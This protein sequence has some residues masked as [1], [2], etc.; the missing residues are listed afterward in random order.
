[1]DVNEDSSRTLVRSAGAMGVM[2]LM[3]RVLGYVRDLLLAAILGAAGSSDAFIIALRIPNLLRRL[4][5][6][7]ALTAAFVPVFSRRLKEGGR[8]AAGEL[9]GRALGT[10]SLVLAILATAGVLF[11]PLVLRLVAFGFSRSQ[12]KWDLTVALNRLM[13]PYLL[14]I[15]LAALAMAALNSLRSFAV[16]AFTPVLLNLSII[17]AALVLGRRMEE[18]AYAF[19]I[20]VLVGG[21][22]Q[23]AF[24]LPFLARRGMS[25]RPRLA[26][27]DRDIRRIALLMIPGVFGVAVHQINI[28][29]DAQFASFLPSGSVSWLYY[30]DRVTELVLGVFAISV[31]TVVLPTLSRQ[32]LAG[33][34]E[35]M[36]DTL[37][38]ALRLIAFVTIPAT[39]G[40]LLLRLP[41]I[42]VLFQRGEFGATDALNTSQALLGY[43]VG[44]LP[45]AA[46]KVLAPAFYAH[47]DTATPVKVAVVTLGVHVVLCFA[48]IGPMQHTGI[49]L[50]TS[51]SS[52]LNT[53]LLMWLLR[54]RLGRDIW[55]REIFTSAAQFV[56]CG[57][58]MALCLW[59]LQRW[60]PFSGMQGAGAAAG[61]LAAAVSVGVVSYGAAHLAFGGREL[62]ELLAILPGRGGRGGPQGGAR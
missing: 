52:A 61:W 55:R 44:L 11:S 3:S 42:T 13:F 18:P 38:L 45:F 40:L 17:T 31:S 56:L 53:V 22:L 8:Q 34:G 25:V 50:A 12:E 54:R 4:V 35:R 21:F 26:F 5:G 29:V 36:R 39:I 41:I 49:A 48:L 15:G 43:G 28:I 24:Q 2:T 9:L 47:Q 23:I 10:L 33:D 6:E 19:A 7:G 60:Q 58:V 14:F 27:G 46:V 20:G 59:L 51:A 1:M 32:V 37:S 62:R 30:G 16:P 57:G